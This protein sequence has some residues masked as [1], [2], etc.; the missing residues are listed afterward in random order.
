MIQDVHLQMNR[1]N[2]VQQ[3]QQHL[4]LQQQKHQQHS[5]AENR[6]QNNAS[7]ALVWFT[8]FESLSKQNSIKMAFLRK[9]GC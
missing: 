2:Q 6:D 1:V 7:A 4:I 5:K 3:Q 8:L 9:F